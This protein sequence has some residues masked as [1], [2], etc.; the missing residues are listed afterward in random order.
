[1]F[2]KEH[3]VPFLLGWLVMAWVLPPT[4]LLGGLGAKKAS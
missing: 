2:K 4:K 1:M 3:L